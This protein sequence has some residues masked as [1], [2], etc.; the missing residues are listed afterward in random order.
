MGNIAGRSEH[1]AEIFQNDTVGAP[2][3][4]AARPELN[5]ADTSAPRGSDAARQARRLIAAAN[6]L[7]ALAAELEEVSRQGRPSLISSAD[8]ILGD[9]PALLEDDARW[10]RGARRSYRNRRSRSAVFGDDGLFGEPAWDLLLDLFIAAKEGKRVPVTSAC[11][12]AAVPTTTA[13]RWLAVLE[14]RGL[15]VREADPSDARRIFV[16]LS[17]DAYARMVSYFVR[18]AMNDAED[19]IE[20]ARA[21]GRAIDKAW[22]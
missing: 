2:A 21:N 11:I 1:H 13:L 4:A 16:R 7:L 15:V 12:G 17:T 20:A 5:S 14:E 19:T 10:L 3:P 8:S 18:T 22:S 9:A 6:E